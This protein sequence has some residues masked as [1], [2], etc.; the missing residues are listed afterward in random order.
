MKAIT[1]RFHGPSARRGA[2]L[3]ARDMDGNRI[4]VPYPDEGPLGEPRYR[5]AAEALCRKMGWSGPLV[6]GAIAA[7]YV[8]V[9]L[10]PAELPPESAARRSLSRTPAATVRQTACRHCGLDIEGWAPY[11]RGTWRDRGNNTHC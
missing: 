2:R 10:D 3:S 1:V 9:F 6:G 7:G 8:F 11:R 4:T 5:V